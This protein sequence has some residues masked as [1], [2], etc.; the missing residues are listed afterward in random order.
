MGNASG[1][2]GE[3]WGGLFY[4]R[5]ASLG[6]LGRLGEA[7]GM[8]GNAS[9]RLG[10]ARGLLGNASGRLGEAISFLRKSLWEDG[11]KSI[12]P[13]VSLEKAFGKMGLNPSSH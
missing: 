4:P 10:E 11:I 12:F 6:K 13:I 5:S 1:R 3:A 7:W 2:L 8:L 9:G